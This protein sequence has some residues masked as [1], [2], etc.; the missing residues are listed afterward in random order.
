MASN[1]EAEPCLPS[2]SR[3][4]NAPVTCK[5][6]PAGSPSNRH[7]K[8]MYVV[9]RRGEEEAVSFDQILRRIELLSQGLHELVD[10]AKVAQAVINGMFAGIRTSQL[11]ELAAQTSAYMAVT[12]PDFS[13]LAARI[14]IDNLHK[15]TSSDLVDVVDAL[16]GF[17]DVLGRP[18][19]L[20]SEP[21]ANFIRENK[22]ALNAAIDYKRDFE[23]DYFAF[24][25]LERSYL[26]RVNGQISERPQH[27]LMRVACG[28]HT[29]DLEGAVE[30]YDLLSKK[31]FTQATPTL[32]NA[33]TCRPQMSSCF[34]LT[35]QA[36]SIDGIF[37]T[38]RQ[39]ALISKTAGGLGLSVSD[40]R[41][42][43][44]YIRG[45]NGYSNGLVPMLRVFNDASRYVDQGGGKRKG[46]LA[47]YLEPWHP[48]V[49][50]YL[51]LRKN[52]GKE[53]MRARDLFFA[54]WVPDL[55][56][57]RVAEGGSWTLMCPNECPGL[58]TTWGDEFD[59][60]YVKYEREGRGR[61]SVS[62]Q[63]LWFAIL[64]SQIETGTPFMC[65]KDACNRKSNQQNL[66]TIKCSNLCCEIVQY[67]S[68]DE[69][70]VCNLASLSLPS[71]V[72]IERK[73][74]N[75]EKLKRVV[76]VVTRNLNKIIDRNYYPVQE[77]KNSN[78]RHRP[79]GIGVQGLADAFIMLRY[80][81]ES[82][83]AK[84]LNKN[85]FEC[86]YFA[87]LEASMELAKRD[88]P[89]ESYKGSPV[90]N[91]ILQ[92]DMWG[93][94]PTS[95]LCDWDGLRGKIRQYGVRNSLLVS[96]MPTAS[97]SQIL[98]NNEA[99]EPYTSNLYCRRVLSGEFFV[100][101]P[102][103]LND[104][105]KLNLWSE[106][107]MQELIAH[108][109]SVQHID[110]IP[111]DLKELYKTVW[112]IKQR[113]IVDMSADRAPYV[114]QSQSLNIHMVNP[115]F[116]KLSTM[117][118]HGWKLGLKTGLYYLRTQA[119]VDAIKFTVDTAILKD[120]QSKAS[121]ES[122]GVADVNEKRNPE[123]YALDGGGN[124][125]ASADMQSGGADSLTK[126]TT[127]APKVCRLRRGVNDDEPCLMCSG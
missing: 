50:D 87:A 125:R 23:Y 107:M 103:L 68:P 33:G 15:N 9:N 84:E 27:M 52:H 54:L 96:T 67:C 112:E 56:M 46:S 10:P 4:E 45:T 86:I 69:V 110:G 97:T 76:K 34:L 41:A 72:N 82:A 47:I 98:G 26:L 5:L 43:G 71:F 58:T 88:G 62:A 114:D 100:C 28:I 48:D 81:F 127:E 75:F 122:G 106:K 74:Y 93:V 120:A 6:D 78:L 55:F 25:T 39:C 111:N 80:P 24:K 94:Q 77:A 57:K 66:G 31:Y 109:G 123:S 29:G 38:L 61:K 73:S 8:G 42:S 22:D 60:L 116:S 102:H 83:Q 115:S 126:M 18:A 108:N 44:S 30:T 70:A 65:Y 11:D 13:K 92:F 35:M 79:I 89:Y 37:G 105:L 36:D 101:N 121:G 63:S 51:N 14:A 64:Q 20:L 90:S 118:F 59:K 124:D 53:E 91:G 17:K 117:H 32:F 2:F 95:G 119:A 16:T 12:H 104:L 113:C 99:F 7:G 1:D 21:V 19:P 85:I 3:V 49:F 40:I